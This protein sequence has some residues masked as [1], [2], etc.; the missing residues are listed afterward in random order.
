MIEV[1]Y[2]RI[3]AI[4][5][6]IVLKSISSFASQPPHPKRDDQTRYHNEAEESGQE[7]CAKYKRCSQHSQPDDE[8]DSLADGTAWLRIHR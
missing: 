1:F 5:H 6:I 8:S 4:Q 7:E 3:F 2:N